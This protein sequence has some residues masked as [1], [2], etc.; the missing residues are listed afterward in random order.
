MK[1]AARHLAAEYRK[2]DDETLSR[3]GR[4]IGQLDTQ[5]G[6]QKQTPDT[7][8]EGWSVRFTNLGDY[9]GD[10]TP[11]QPSALRVTDG[12]L[13]LYDGCEN[14]VWGASGCGKS[15]LAVLAVLQEI[16][17]GRRVVVVDYEM[18]QRDWVLRLMS[19]GATK[20]QLRLVE[21]IAP[22]EPLRLKLGSYFSPV[23]DITRAGQI[24]AAEL[25]AAVER[26]PISLA[27]IDGVTEM[28]S[29]NNL[30]SNDAE[31]IAQ[32]WNALP[33]LITR[34]TGAALLALDHV[35]RAHT[36]ANQKD[37][38]P[39]GS[40]HKLSR[41]KGA[42][43]SAY[44]TAIPTK[45]EY[46]GQVGL[47]HLFCKKDRHGGVGQGRDR[48][49]LEITPLPGGAVNLALLPFSAERANAGQSLHDQQVAQVLQLVYK[50]NQERA[51]GRTTEKVTQ[52]SLAAE[53]EA[54]GIKLGRDA[55]G[56]LLANMAKNGLVRNDGAKVKGGAQDWVPTNWDQPPTDQKHA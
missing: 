25:A 18:S 24:L 39:L 23:E 47:L 15:W 31:D 52:R 19:A 40:Q 34:T 55:I 11:R 35:T 46:G 28:L 38:L 9:T 17:A 6:E 43:F 26:G 49:T 8:P 10:L 36:L 21:Y 48:A 7:E 33:A 27:V 41:V 12:S 4:E 20:E 32:M 5:G 3:L 45:L 56:N 42:G 51:Q 16:Q 50:L 44:A 30:G 29:S 22:Q 14:L 13:L 53:A 54:Q 1:A 37:T 2:A